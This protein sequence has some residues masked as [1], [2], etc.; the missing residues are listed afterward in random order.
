MKEKKMSN[1]RE[2]KRLWRAGKVTNASA[3][4]GAELM[5]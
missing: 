1:R 3:G 5:L 2:K 4:W